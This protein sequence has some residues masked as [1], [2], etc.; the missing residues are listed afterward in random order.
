VT[1]RLASGASLTLGPG[2][3][4]E[5][6]SPTRV[7]LVTGE[8]KLEASQDSPVRLS[9]P[10]P[11]EQ[12]VAGDAMIFR[13][14][15]GKLSRL[16]QTPHW[17]LGF[18]G[19][20]SD[21]SIGSLVAKV[22]GRNVP[23]SVGYHRVRIDIRDQVARTVIEE[24][25]VNHTGGLLEGVF[26]FP[27]PPDA[28]I[29]GFGMWIGGG[30]IEADIVEKQ[31][32]REIY[33][34]ILRERR[35]P[36]LLEWTGGNVFKAR[37]F[38]IEGHSEKRIKI[39]YTQVLPQHDGKYRYSYP[40]QS[41]LLKQHPL[42]ELDID[43]RL[44]S[45][46]GI[47]AVASPT[48]PEARVQRTAHSARVEFAA[49]EYA[50]GSDFEVVVTAEKDQPNLVMVPHRRGEDGYFM[51]MLQPPGAPGQW[52]RE[53]VADGEPLRLLVLAD[54][55]G[56][57]NAAAREA[58][59]QFVGAL[60]SSLGPKDAFNLATCDV[61]CLWAFAE[62]QAANEA[63]IT[64]A[65]EKLAGRV[66]LGWTDLDKAF[67]SA[68]SQANDSTHVVYV[69]DGIVTTRDADPASFARRLQLLGKGKQ[70]AM[71][72]IATSSSFEPLVLNAIASHGGGSLRRITGE[73]TPQSSAAELLQ[74]MTRPSLH[75]LRVEFDGVQT[76]QVYP[77]TLPNLPVGDQQ[78]VLGRYLPTD[79]VQ[80]GKVVVTGTLGDEEVRFQT[81]VTL[82]ETA[83]AADAEQDSS[84]IPRLWARR[85][86]DALLE[87][88]ASQAV[89]DEIIGLSEEHHLMTPYTSLLVL[90]TDEDRER[91]KV[92]RRFE[93]RD[94]QRY[95]AE[96]RD[97]TNYD[98]LSDQGRRAGAWRLGLRRQVLAE[99][100]GLGRNGG[101]LQP[102]RADVRWAS[103][104]RSG[105]VAGR[106]WYF[107][108]FG[109]GDGAVLLGGEKLRR[110]SDFSGPVSGPMEEM[111]P[112]TSYLDAN[113]SRMAL[114]ELGE[115]T[116]GE[117][118]WFE[119]Q[120]RESS[121][122]SW[123]V[124][125]NQPF[126]GPSSLG[127]A[128]LYDGAKR[129]YPQSQAAAGGFF[130]GTAWGGSDR[131]RGRRG[132][133]LAGLFN[134]QASNE[135]NFDFA[136]YPVHRFTWLDELFPQL[137]TTPADVKPATSLEPWPEEARRLADALLRTN[138][139]ADLPGGLRIDRVTESGNP[140]WGELASRRTTLELVSP[141]RWLTRSQAAG[142]QTL[143]NWC[144]R[145]HRGVFSLGF[146]LGRRR[147][148]AE[149]DL[150]RPPLGL[151][152]HMMTSLERS[153]QNFS[154]R[155]EPAEDGQQ[156]LVL[157]QR[158]NPVDSVRY[159]IDPQRRVVLSVEHLHHGEV[160]SVTRY[161]QFVEVAGAWWPGRTQTFDDQSR[162]T[163]VTTDAF[164]PLEA[165]AFDAD[166][167]NHLSALPLILLISGPLPS[168]A[169]ARRALEA[170]A[171]SFSDRIMLLLSQGER[172]Q[173]E[174][175]TKQLAS[176][177]E[178]AQ[179]KPGMRWVRNAV[180]KASRGH[181]QLRQ[182][183]MATATD[184][185][186]HA[187]AEDLFLANHLL[188]QASGV[189]AANET[190]ALLDA[191]KPVY[192]RQPPHTFAMRSW[193]RAR[194]SQLQ[195]VGRADEALAVQQRLAKDYPHDAQAQ[196][197]YARALFNAT[198][199]RQAFAWLDQ[200]ITD[201]ANWPAGE[202]QQLRE[203]YVDLLESLGRWS[204]AADYLERWIARNPEAARPYER[205]LAALL[206]LDQIEPMNALIDEWL[207]AARQPGELP[208]AALARLNAAVAQAQGRGYAIRTNRLDERWLDPLADTVRFFALHEN[209]A[210]IAEQIM[211]DG[212]F[213]D[214]DQ[215]RALRSEYLRVLRTDAA[216][217]KPAELNRL[218]GWVLANDPAVDNDPWKEI[219][220]A[221]QQRWAGAQHNPER[222]QLTQA[223][224]SILSNRFPEEHLEFLR[225]RLAADSKEERA[226]IANALFNT[227]LSRAWSAEREDELLGLLAKLAEPAADAD[228]RLATE[229]QALYRL[230]DRMVQ[231]RYEAA[232]AEVDHQDELSRTE[233]QA[234][235]TEMLRHARKAFVSRLHK[236]EQQGA[237]R[238]RPWLAIER[239]YLQMQVGAE[240]DRV[241]EECWRYVDSHAAP[242]QTA[243]GYK[244]TSVRAQLDNILYTRHLLT[245]ANLATRTGARPELAIRL[246]A[247]VDKTIANTPVTEVNWRYFKYQLL[248][249]LDRPEQ[250]ADVLRQWLREDDPL[251]LWRISLAYLLAEQAKLK[252]A[253]TLL[254]A[255]QDDGELG[256][257]EHRTLADWRLALNERE[258]YD[259]AMVEVYAA[260]PEWQLQNRLWQQLRPWQQYNQPTPGEL[261]KS[262]FQAFAALLRKSSAPQNYMSMLQEYYRTTR[263]FR[264]LACLA[265]AMPGHTP[266]RVYPLLSSLGGVFEEVREEAT[267]DA[268]VREIEQA[269]QRAQTPLDRRALDLLEVMVERRAS[270]LQNQ[271][272]PHAQRA[273]AALRRAFE[274]EW[275]PGEQPQMAEFLAALGT[276]REDAFAQEQ[277]RELRTLH[278]AAEAGAQTRLEIADA[279]ARCLWGYGEHAA[280]IDQLEASLNEHHGSH[281]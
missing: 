86:L 105:G 138:A 261:D 239:L 148:A 71:H 174:L 90:E 198:E 121:R 237:E 35:D 206:R 216:T 241:A 5:L 122:V 120:S 80:H 184:L 146:D 118:D 223:L 4:A 17:L 158:N 154:A 7:R 93:M 28:S 175:A 232:M 37:V 195:S 63:N 97:N 264:L 217:L 106:S 235:Q 102:Q 266:Q 194:V 108:G 219:A 95:F 149:R 76:A 257:S 140:H 61:D 13:V 124:E 260:M 144:D 234:K 263:D 169:D 280:A 84:F 78:I 117:D 109:G 15:D 68:L 59:A 14:T 74:E 81:E 251:H 9:G 51:L 267:V 126:D 178:L 127:F 215:C 229:T 150:S 2:S 225:A 27:L 100:M 199:R 270:L 265:N 20:T 143:V 8:A 41:D 276:V 137:S 132:I 245:L 207:R 147:A 212:A 129:L 171:A 79:K 55:S 218:I 47:G 26:Y 252:E 182:R 273:L 152:S 269:R 1:L 23:L 87:Q 221:I 39:S 230:T 189:L 168:H 208:P 70:A 278:S 163:G 50:P 56:S 274:R 65:R 96:G 77:R 85:R 165:Q 243:E 248:V 139:L 236:A 268:M 247:I 58:Q 204:D 43:L 281:G 83:E 40:L 183:L 210:S 256:P 3:L 42:R 224:E 142:D 64:A 164:T 253:A 112:L 145:K 211:N 62:S 136:G 191:L 197:D 29:S 141:T 32:A 54:T 277:L 231:A 275:A 104:S 187:F 176:A 52:R 228:Q 155:V 10:A 259:Q 161:D 159:L 233:L 213:R 21:Q 130:A 190:L 188:N 31:R 123:D 156:A 131:T 57:M 25:F 114:D 53:V 244:R 44:H 49:Q 193:Q 135:R 238:L 18:E 179:D 128:E 258:K 255:V 227:L 160:T 115:W 272:G 82:E 254:E 116:S 107:D 6:T 33:E 94:A 30:L 113:Y 180:L 214:S 103:S 240:L 119:S 46:S 66:S 222:P 134:Y 246:L 172:G 67:E 111:A 202:E 92:K 22:D 36:G 16:T 249:A 192:Q 69:G 24:S 91:F 181:E 12:S 242:G 89:Q 200:V 205:R 48:H 88:G 185:A 99:L 133:G 209:H 186:Q 177:E 110:L 72:A 73:P 226:S 196:L 34:T 19:A 173:W 98:L 60:L 167:D 38:P 170:G 250:L 166:L 201:E 271:P 75:N 151:P 157:T 153:H 162:R 45:S 125:L 203:T 11:G 101:A 262:V 220:H 279:L